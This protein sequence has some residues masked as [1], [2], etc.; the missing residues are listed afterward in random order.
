MDVLWVSPGLEG[1]VV[2]KMMTWAFGVLLLSMFTGTQIWQSH[3]ART[4]TSKDSR[5][6]ISCANVCWMTPSATSSPGP[7]FTYSSKKGFMFSK[8]FI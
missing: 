2:L 5:A 3:C 8:L 4:E 7:N 6:C 1:K